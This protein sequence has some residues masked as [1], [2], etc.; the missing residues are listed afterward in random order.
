MYLLVTRCYLD[1]SPINQEIKIFNKSD[2][3]IANICQHIANLY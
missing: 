3:S 2:P 1:L